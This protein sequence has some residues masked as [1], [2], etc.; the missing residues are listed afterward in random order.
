M[1]TIVVGIVVAIAA[2]ALAVGLVA[3]VVDTP[4]LFLCAGLL[5]AVA[6]CFLLSWWGF[7]LTGARR[8]RTGAA[9][10]SAAIGVAVTALAASTI[11]SPF[12]AQPQA[13]AP[14]AVQYWD[15][16]TGSRIAYVHAPAAELPARS[17]R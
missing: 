15:L 17:R 5:V 11:L 2:G 16:P 14:S 13:G 4:A 6:A 3:A 7:R 10:L 1:A 12:P 9:G 8:A